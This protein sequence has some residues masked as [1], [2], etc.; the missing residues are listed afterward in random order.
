MRWFQTLFVLFFS[1]LLYLYIFLYFKVN[2][3]NEFT[4]LDDVCKDS[5]MNTIHYKLPIVFDG[6]NIMPSYDL[7]QCTKFDKS[8]ETKFDKSNKSNKNIFLKTYESV[9]MLEPV[10]K[11]FTKDTLYKLKKNKRI[12]LHKNL[13]CRNFY[14]VHKGSINV[15]CI[16]PKYKEHLLNDKTNDKVNDFIDKHSQI[17]HVDLSENSIL[18]VPNYWYVS[19]K[20]I[21]DAIV[22][23]V[24]YTTILNKVNFWLD[25]YL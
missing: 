22:E 21:D 16:H 7:S 10:V 3:F 25:K 24:Q 13:E 8:N 9:P 15:S 1:I 6:T 19:I 17:L 23:K 5:I 11:Y 20:A 4:V 2:G 18:F 12:E 14:L